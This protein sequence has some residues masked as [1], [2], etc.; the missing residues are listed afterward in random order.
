MKLI[1]TL[2]SSLFAVVLSASAFADSDSSTVD[3]STMAAHVQASKGVMIRVPVDQ[4]GRELAAAS[5]IR[6][7]GDAAT[8]STGANLADIWNRGVD[9]TKVPQV[10][11]STSSDSSTSAWRWG[12]NPWRPY[13]WGWYNPYYYN[14][15]YPMYYNYGYTYNYGYPVY[16]NYYNPYVYNGVYPVWGWRYYYYPRVW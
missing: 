6:V 3:S 7:V 15:Y 5:E 13:N 8:Q 14:N 2:S 12:W 9:A 1:K 16:Y 11:S 10:D 4:Q